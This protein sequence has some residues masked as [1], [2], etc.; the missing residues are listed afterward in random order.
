M[1]KNSELPFTI[2]EAI[3]DSSV[4]GGAPIAWRGFGYMKTDI[5][6][7]VACGVADRQQALTVV[8]ELRRSDLLVNNNGRLGLDV[9]KTLH[10]LREWNPAIEGRHPTYDR[11]ADAIA[12]LMDKLA[13]A[14]ATLYISASRSL[15]TA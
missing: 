9:D 1:K 3:L 5:V 11:V 10:W 6:N 13:A 12:R 7:R 8:S 15:A 2:I 14:V 4:E